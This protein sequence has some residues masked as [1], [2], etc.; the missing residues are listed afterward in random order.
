M[1]GLMPG[2]SVS[3]TTRGIAESGHQGHGR[4]AHYGGLH[5]SE[6]DH[7]QRGMDHYRVNK[8]SVWQAPPPQGYLDEEA[9]VFF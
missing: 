4:Q 2:N 1:N 6:F 9:G 8:S 7:H 3:P 5:P